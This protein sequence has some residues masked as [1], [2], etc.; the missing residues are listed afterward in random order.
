MELNIKG[1][2]TIIDDED[3]DLI[4]EYSWRV[5]SKEEKQEMTIMSVKLET[6]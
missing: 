4:K 3:Y 5:C 6:V 2:V 1:Y